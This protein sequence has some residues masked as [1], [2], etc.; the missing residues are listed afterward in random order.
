MHAPQGHWP[1]LAADFLER[2]RENN[3]RVHCIT[4]NVAQNFTANVL[5]AAGAIPSMTISTDEV[6][7]FA[8]RADALL[9]NLG[10]FDAERRA[11]ANIAIEEFNRAQEPWVLDPVLIDRSAPRAEFARALAS[12]LPAAI[13]LNA[14]EFEALDGRDSL[15]QYAQHHNSVLALTGAVD[16][17]TD[18]ANVIRIRNG[19]PLMARITAMGCAEGA[20]IAAMLAI[21]PDRFAA[22]VSSVLIFGIA[23]DIAG[24]KANGPGSFGVHFLDAIHNLD[25]AAIRARAKLSS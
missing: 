3:P 12:R 16:L 19:H 8:R 2:L 6:G 1:D 20:F 21:E 7:A 23:G 22:V 18:G 15:E 24:E 17:V 14:S 5:L 10:T 13:R 11:A 9:V 25:R 4:N